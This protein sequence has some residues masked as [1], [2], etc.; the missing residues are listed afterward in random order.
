MGNQAQVQRLHI[1]LFTLGSNS[2]IIAGR[3]DPDAVIS[4]PCSARQARARKV[5]AGLIANVKPVGVN[6]SI[7]GILPMFCV[8]NFLEGCIQLGLSIALGADHFV[9]HIDPCAGYELKQTCRG[10]PTDQ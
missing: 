9:F 10:D 1:L 4:A 5:D 2:L 6:P 8:L 3:S 7:N